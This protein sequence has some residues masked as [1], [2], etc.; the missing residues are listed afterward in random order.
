M[1]TAC[2]VAHGGWDRRGGDMM[3]AMRWLAIEMETN[4][5]VGGTSKDE[6][7]TSRRKKNHQ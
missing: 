1:V 3:V 6:V 2:A 5:M 7:G 4:A